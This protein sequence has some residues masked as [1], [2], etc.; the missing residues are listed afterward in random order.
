MAIREIVGYAGRRVV[1]AVL[2]LLVVSVAIF[3]L[4]HL[5]PG[6]PEQAVAGQ[7][8]TPEQLAAIRANLGL[9]DPLPIQYLRF[10]GDVARLDLGNSFSTREPVVASIQS[11]L[12]VTAPLV[13]IS[14]VLICTIGIALGTLAAYRAGGPIDRAAMGLALVGASSPAFVTAVVLLTV[15]GVELGWLPVFGTGEGLVDRAQHLVLPIVTLTIA[16]VAAMLHITRTRVKQVLEED[17]VTF[18]RARDLS[19][20]HVMLR[21]VLRNAGIQI[22]TQSG[23]IFVGLVSWVL[24]VEV[25]FGLDGAGALLADAIAA[26]DIPVIQGVT[27]LMAAFIVAVNVLVDLLYSALDPRVRVEGAGRPT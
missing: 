4:V 3:L 18:A 7:F 8:A 1:G 23:V 5:A 26:R 11:G 9:D 13:L 2:V 14:F 10:L 20:T 15:F 25:T 22:V 24:L 16:G 12:T 27:L 21:S 19:P 6:G 17:H